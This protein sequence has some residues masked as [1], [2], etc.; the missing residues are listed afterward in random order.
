MRTALLFALVLGIAPA[1][2]AQAANGKGAQPFELV[3]ELQVFQNESVLR[4]KSGQSERRQRIKKIAAQLLGYDAK[5]WADPK[6]ARAAVIYVLSGGDPR[7]LRKLT[8]SHVALGIDDRLVKGAL[9]YGERQDA[10]AT[11]LLDGIELEALDRSIAGH[12]ALVR[13]LLIAKDESR[14]AYALLDM[15]RVVAPGTIVEEAALRHQALLAANMDELDEFEGLSS[16]Y[17]RRFSNSVFAQSFQRQF[18]QEIASH[19]YGGDAVRMAKLEALLSALPENER[20]DVCLTVAEEA[21]VRANVDVVR[22]AAQIAAIDG[23]KRNSDATRLKLFGAAA[24][25]V[26][27]DYDQG[28]TALGSID[29]AKLGAREEGLLDAALAVARE[30]SRPPAPPRGAK[31]APDAEEKAESEAIDPDSANVI[32]DAEES[33]AR[34]DKLLNEAVRP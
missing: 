29:R 15:A 23:K 13:A 3:R 34:A 28:L 17:F 16:Q 5:V 1:I 25:I 14:K 22:L 4:S 6:N 2:A 19:G 20:N 10:K 7:V 8:A 24:A 31:S 18:A 32:R 27:A 12:V 30:I 26:T 21:I 11:E 9:A 33:M